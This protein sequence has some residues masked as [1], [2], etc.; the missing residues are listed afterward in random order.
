MEIEYESLVA[1]AVA[2][3]HG[4]DEVLMALLACLSLSDGWQ[5]SPSQV[6]HSPQFLS[7]KS[8]E[9]APASA[10]CMRCSPM[11]EHANSVITGHHFLQC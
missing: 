1:R 4:K 8:Q 11:S 9:Y 5:C 2:N 7:V 10:D 6:I 3:N